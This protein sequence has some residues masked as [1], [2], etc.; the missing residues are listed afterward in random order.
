VRRVLAIA[1]VLGLALAAQGAAAQPQGPRCLSLTILRHKGVIYFHH[2]LKTVARPDLGAKQGIGM[3]RACDDTPDPTEPPPWYP[4]AVRALDG[5]S[6][7]MAL[8]PAGR[9]QVVFY[10]IY[11]CTPRF[12]ETRFLR[13]LRR[14]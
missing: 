9:R 13:C 10:D 14:R 6:P 5:I 7:K 11:R 3:E 4:T 12:G 2:K 8:A 1:V